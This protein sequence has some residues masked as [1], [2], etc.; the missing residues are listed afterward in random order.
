MKKLIAISDKECLE[1]K[2]ALSALIDLYS[3]ELHEP[4]DGYIL[5]EGTVLYYLDHIEFAEKLQK[6]FL[7]LF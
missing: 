5:A 4:A 7:R 2:K 1:I 6:K 3:K